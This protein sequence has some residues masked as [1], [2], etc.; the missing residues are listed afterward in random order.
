MTVDGRR[1]TFFG[2]AGASAHASAASPAP[3]PSRSPASFDARISQEKRKATIARKKAEVEKEEAEKEEA[4]KEEAEKAA[5]LK[6]EVE[7]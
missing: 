2:F 6:E 1:S 5:A 7:A 4:E 3:T